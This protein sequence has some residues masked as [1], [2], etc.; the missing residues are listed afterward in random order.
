MVAYRMA[1]ECSLVWQ[2]RKRSSLSPLVKTY[3]PDILEH[4]FRS[5]AQDMRQA[6]VMLEV[7]EVRR[8][9]ITEAVSRG[10]PTLLPRWQSRQRQRQ[11][12]SAQSTRPWQ[13]LLTSDATLQ[14]VS[15]NRLRYLNAPL[16]SGLRREHNTHPTLPP[17]RRPSC[18]PASACA[19][20]RPSV[21]P[22]SA[23]TSA[24]PYR[25]DGR[26]TPPPRP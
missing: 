23:T 16:H 6:S 21:S 7:L 17:D 24:A 5:L 26:A 3:L 8:R 20:S 12:N 25:E 10:C 9:S 15:A 19:P 14:S 1:L 18:P 2:C 11:L 13:L 22:P 4:P